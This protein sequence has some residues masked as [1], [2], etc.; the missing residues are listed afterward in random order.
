MSLTIAELFPDPLN[1]HAKPVQNLHERPGLRSLSVVLPAFNEQYNLRTTVEAARRIL[2]TVAGQWEI[3]IVNDGSGDATG[4][5]CDGLANQFSEVRV[6]HHPGNKG[7]G[8]ALKSGITVARHDWIFFSDS[9]GQFDFAEISRL[10]AHSGDNDI[11]A[12]YR[13][14]RN[15]PFYRALNAAGWNIL[16]RLSLGVAVRDID[17]AFKLFRRQVFERVQIRSVG[18]MVNTEILSQAF[19]FGM[20]I[21]EVE[22]THYPRQHGQPSGAKPRV[23]IKA[24]R[25]LVRMWWKLRNIGHEQE[26]LYPRSQE[27]EAALEMDSMA[28]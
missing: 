3:I 27:P 18:A 20:R 15:D 12:G 6:V 17:C 26:G 23:I 14:R 8:A 21:K 24:F 28:G 13:K 1:S 25:E 16:V 7:Y 2:P 22:V 4:R 19:R 11:V 5:I 9:D 10:L